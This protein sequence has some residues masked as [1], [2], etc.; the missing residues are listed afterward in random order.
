MTSL[1][2]AAVRRANAAAIFAVA[3][4]VLSWGSA[5]PLIRVGMRDLGALELAAA[6]FAVASALALAWLAF[7]RP[8]PPTRAD[9][10]R[11]LVCG[12]IGISALQR[13]A[14]SGRAHRQRRRGGV[15]RQRRA[16]PDRHSRHRLSA[17]AVFGL[18]L[19]RRADELRRRRPDR[20]RPA[21]RAGVRRRGEPRRRGG[22]VHGELFRLAAPARPPL[23]RA[24][25]H[26]LH[27]ARRGAVPSAVPARRAAAFSSRPAAARAA[28]T[29]VALGVFPA[30]IGYAAWTYALGRFGAARAANFLYL[31][32][33]VAALVGYAALGESLSALTLVGGADR[34][35]RRRDCE[36]ARAPDRQ[37]APCRQSRAE[38]IEN[39]RAPASD[40]RTQ[41]LMSTVDVKPT[42][43]KPSGKAESPAEPFKRALA[44]CTRAMARRPDLEVAFAADKPA[45]VSGPEGARARLPE[46][47]RKPNA[48]EA[49]ILRG[50][51]DSMAL[52][53]A[54]H[55]DAVHRRHAPHN[56]AARALFDAAEQARVEAIGARRMEGVAANLTAMLDD[57]YHRAPYSE[58]R[59]RDEAP[60]EDAVAMLVRERLTGLKPPSGAARVVELWRPFVEAK[61]AAELDGLGASIHDQRGFARSLHRLLAFARPAQRLGGRRRR[62]RGIGRRGHAARARRRRRWR[63]RAPG[64]RR[65]D[66]EG[67]V[68]RHRR[69]TR[70]R[71]DRSRRS[72]LGRLPRRGRGRRIRGSGG[73]PPAAADR[74]AARAGLQGLHCQVRR[75]RQRRGPVRAGG[76]AAAARLSRQAAAEP[77][78]RRRP[79]RQPAAAAADGAAEPLVGVRPRGGRARR[80]PPV[81]RRHRLRSSRCRSSARR[82]WTSATRW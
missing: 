82:T 54:C 28:A 63:R 36:F 37:R 31:V 19:G 80:R 10:G 47:P 56:P 59:E 14:Q 34:H 4:T 61:A 78:Q 46:P 48:R 22:A 44:S 58:A 70:G 40:A 74:R 17:R 9:A 69:R 72:A 60:L 30:A 38:P 50:I 6:R 53:L 68:G 52:R 55:N 20:A 73:E 1:S 24:R 67:G 62:E 8:P 66:G 25:L 43:R 79:A 5:F 71:R 2:S 18:G 33:P 41:A 76:I 21:G 42:N 11:F 3:V 45:L 23:R 65:L 57:R 12:L 49:A 77:L 39:A 32:P 81:A 16:D 15:H 27:A 13:P 7:R 75:G 29:V 64:I 35:S 51:A 26:R